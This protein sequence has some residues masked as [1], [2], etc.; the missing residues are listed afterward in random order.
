MT[1]GGGELSFGLVK[2]ATISAIFVYYS[3][4]Y[5]QLEESRKDIHSVYSL[6]STSS[7]EGQELMDLELKPGGLL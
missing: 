5:Q 7:K 3:L 6:A 2:P 4:F 1:G